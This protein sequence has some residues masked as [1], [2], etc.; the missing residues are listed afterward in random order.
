[1]TYSLKSGSTLVAISAGTT[2][3]TRGDV[4]IVRLL[5]HCGGV[6]GVIDGE[7]KSLLSCTR[8]SESAGRLLQVVVGQGCGCVKMKLLKS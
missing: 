4:G 7:M 2:G 6:G 3:L 5:G 8:G 1:M